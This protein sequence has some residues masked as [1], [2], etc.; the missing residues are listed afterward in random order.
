MWTRK[1]VDFI[2]MALLLLG[3]AVLL[4]RLDT[5]EREEEPPVQPVEVSD[6]QLPRDAQQT[7]H[8]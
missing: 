5:P 7:F 1:V 8:F 2:V 4:S 3:P 6:Y